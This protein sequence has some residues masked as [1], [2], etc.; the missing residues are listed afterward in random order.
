[1]AKEKKA[2]EKEIEEH[3]KLHEEITAYKSKKTA[4]EAEKY[5]D[6]N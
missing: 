5:K 4:E 6:K 3:I 2:R 1:M